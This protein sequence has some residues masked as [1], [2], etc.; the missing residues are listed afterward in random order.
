[1]LTLD[2][3]YSGEAQLI[4]EDGVYGDYHKY[5]LDSIHSLVVKHGNF[6]AKLGFPFKALGVGFGA[7]GG[8]LIWSASS[9][10][11]PNATDDESSDALSRLVLGIGTVGLGTGFFILGKKI[12]DR[13]V[14]KEKTT[15]YLDQWDVRIV[16]K[17]RVDIYRRAVKN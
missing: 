9:I 7:L 4:T 11:D 6:K 2:F 12:G 13:P 17:S 10:D 8:L 1:M 15:Y 5:P 16:E 3:K 14:E